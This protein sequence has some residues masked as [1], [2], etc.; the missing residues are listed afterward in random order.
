MKYTHFDIDVVF[1]IRFVFIV[2]LERCL[3]EFHNC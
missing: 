2:Q 1:E 3:N